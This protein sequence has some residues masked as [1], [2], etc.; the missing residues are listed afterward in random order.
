MSVAPADAHSPHKAAPVAAVA[1]ANAAE[2]GS[3]SSRSEKPEWQVY[4][5]SLVPRRYEVGSAPEKEP[6]LYSEGG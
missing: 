5:P 3:V 6:S 4:Q 1:Q 2:H